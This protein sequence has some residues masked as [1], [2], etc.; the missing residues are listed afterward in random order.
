MQSK[1]MERAVQRAG[2]ARRRDDGDGMA[3]DARRANDIAFVDRRVRARPSIRARRRAATTTACRRSPRRRIDGRSTRAA[4]TPSSPCNPRCSSE[5]IVAP[6]GD[7]DSTTIAVADRRY[8]VRS[9][10]SASGTYLSQRSYPV[11]ARRVTASVIATAMNVDQTA[12]RRLISQLPSWP[13]I[14][15]TSSARQSW[16]PAARLFRSGRRSL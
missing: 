14:P 9:V 10:E 3:G 1:K 11:S 12:K 2:L 13:S 5:T 16:W 7:R 4:S 8:A 15:R 6:V